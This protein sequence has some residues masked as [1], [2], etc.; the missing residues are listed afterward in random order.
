MIYYKKDSEGIVS[1]T[2]DKSGERVNTIN[3][4]IAKA[5][6]PVLEHLEADKSLKG[7]IIL[8]AKRSFLAGGDLDF[9][10]RAEEPAKIFEHTA[11]LGEIYR[12]FERL[13]VPV[14]AAING[15][16]L[17]SGFELV[18]ACHYRIA[19]DHPRTLL[20][21][22][23]LS[24]GMIPG[25]GG[26]IRLMWMLG[27]EEA[28]KFISSSRQ[29]HVK[30]ALQKG[31][32][33]EAVERPEELIRN[34]K[35]WIL[36]S[37]CIEKPW[38][39]EDRIAK[40]SNPKHPKTAQRI[41]KL[42]TELIAKTRNNYPA[43]LSLLNCMAEGASVDFDAATRINARYF[44]AMIMSKNCR[45]QTK[46]FWYDLNKIKQGMSRPKGFGRFRARKIGVIGAGQMGSGI[47]YVAA[48]QGI[49]VLLRD[50]SKRLAEQGKNNAREKL[51]R[52]EKSGKMTTEQAQEILNRIQT[53]SDLR[54]ME[55]CDLVIEAVFENMALKQRIIKE[56]ELE[57]QQHSFLATN[58]ASL[59]VSDLAQASIQPE[60]YIGMH[61]FSPL[62][63]IPLVEIIVGKKTADE[64]VARAF[65]FVLQLRK[66]P[67]IVQDR[68]AFFVSRVASTYF[69]EGILLLKEGQGPAAI[70]N[71]GLQ[72][73]MPMGPLAFADN[74]G[75]KYIISAEEQAA[76]Q[77][78]GRYQ[79]SPAIA[80]LQEM[81]AQERYGKAR[82]GGFYNY[83]EE[84]VRLWGQLKEN[85]PLAQEQLLPKD[86]QDRLLFIQCLEAVRC[87]EEGVIQNSYDANLGS[88]YGWGFAP[89]K[90]GVIQ[91]INDYGL[92]EFVARAEVLAQRFGPRFKPS[93]SLLEMAEQ[94]TNFL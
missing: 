16:A 92:R 6:L 12:R 55:D 22:P 72:A 36:S 62:N 39:A 24:L 63:R 25:G 57:M 21:L 2:L 17:G 38:D 65:D 50:V 67:I 79:A 9:L 49:E 20:G 59:Q 69:M 61:F 85:F 3:P 52:L 77:L 44:T 66:T 53:T 51:S 10:H 45:N 71:A 14:V 30:E 40:E 88:I 84:P 27:L 43:L 82:N 91:F 1:L 26:I 5:F 90:G 83:K 46:A 78:D 58:T 47:A 35:R 18:L 48:M 23:E 42:S 86:L 8:S 93:A 80:V 81:L 60:N 89:F 94:D 76:Q 54:E 33:D 7:V 34:A 68:P 19:L 32:I 70:E 13:K 28:Y 31:I 15:A 11:L 41:A 29:I 75:F 4:Q 73:G 74:L 64:T 87:L 56:V 37:P